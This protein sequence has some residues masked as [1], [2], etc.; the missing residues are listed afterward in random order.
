MNAYDRVT[1]L[2]RSPLTLWGSLSCDP[3]Q[4]IEWGI[5]SVKNSYDYCFSIFGEEHL[6]KVTLAYVTLCSAGNAAVLMKS[7]NLIPLTI[8]STLVFPHILT[9][10]RKAYEKC[11]AT[12]E[13]QALLP[14]P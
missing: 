7:P 6:G 10:T 5:N 9:L 8:V 2:S 1:T 12:E 11:V 4:T 3:N 14:Q 13:H